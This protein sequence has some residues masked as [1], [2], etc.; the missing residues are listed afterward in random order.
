MT[1]GLQKE[2]SASKLVN[3][4]VK[5]CKFKSAFPVSQYWGLIVGREWRG[6]DIY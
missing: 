6:E 1:L 5:N 2:S 3:K 4:E